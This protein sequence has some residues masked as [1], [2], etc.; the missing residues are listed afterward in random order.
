[1]AAVEPAWQ[2]KFVLY[3]FKRDIFDPLILFLDTRESVFTNFKANASDVPSV[4]RYKSN[5][6][7]KMHYEALQTETKV[8]FHTWN[9][10]LAYFQSPRLIGLL[11][12][13]ESL[14]NAYLKTIESDDDLPPDQKRYIIQTLG[15]LIEQTKRLQVAIEK[16]IGDIVATGD[17]VESMAVF[18]GSSIWEFFASGH[19]V[20]T[21]ALKRVYTRNPVD[22]ECFIVES[23]NGIIHKGGL[24]R[25]YELCRIAQL[26]PTMRMK[27]LAQ[28]TPPPQMRFH[29]LRGS[30]GMEIDACPRD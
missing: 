16:S 9:T 26:T 23:A 27:T 8:L 24:Q 21:S 1:M 19:A 29:I 6:E 18:T 13:V 2:I 4:L 5:L 22:A 10:H 15:G 30:G 11:T 14:Q 17:I 20:R 3:I 12:D 28:A 7:Y 25:V